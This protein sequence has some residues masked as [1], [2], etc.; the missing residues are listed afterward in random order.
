MKDLIVIFFYSLISL[1]TLTTKA[2]TIYSNN[3]IDFTKPIRI[4]SHETSFQEFIERI[5]EENKGSYDYFTSSGVQWNIPQGLHQKISET[6]II[7]PFFGNT[8]VFNLDDKTKKKL[9]TFQEQAQS[10]LDF[11]ASPLSYEN[12]HI[13][14]H[15]LFA[16]QDKDLI[17][18][19]LEKSDAKIQVVFEELRTYISGHPQFRYINL[20]AYQILPSVNTSLVVTFIPCDDQSYRSLFNLYSLFDPIKDLSYFLRPHLTL[21]YF[22]PSVL[23]QDQLSH[24]KDYLLF[25]NN[26]KLFNVKLDLHKLIYQYFD[27]MDD[28]RTQQDL[29]SD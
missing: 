15:D 10:S 8:V 11:L 19:D 12:F 25:V 6:G 29:F 27:S 7:K 4:E 13:T 3:Q 5:K 2:F 22:T 18:K 24:L 21:D 23:S 16:H 26:K 1:V 9:L 20:K 14:L 28:Y 17:V